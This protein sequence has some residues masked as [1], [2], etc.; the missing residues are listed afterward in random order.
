MM[1]ITS[2]AARVFREFEYQTPDSWSRGRR[3]IAK[4]EHVD[5]GTNPRFIATSIPR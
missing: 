3:I 4:A 1:M 2:R 5:K